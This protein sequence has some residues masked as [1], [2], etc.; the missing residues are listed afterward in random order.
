MRRLFHL[1]PLLALAL[2][3]CSSALAPRGGVHAGQGRPP[4]GAAPSACAEGLPLTVRFYDVGQGLAALVRLP[5]GR[6]LLVDTGELAHRSG[7]GDVCPVWHERLMGELRR[8]LPSGRLDLLWI[9]HPHSDHLGG[10]V[11][12]LTAFRTSAYVDNGR[13]AHKPLVAHARAAAEK[14]G[15]RVRVVDPEHRDVPLA[16]SAAVKFS[17]VVPRRWPA[18]CH[19]NENNCSI[20]LRIDYCRSSLLFTGDAEREEEALFDVDRPVTLLQ[21]G[22][23]GSNTSTTPELLA[24]LRPRYAVI[25]VG[26]SDEGT[27]KGFCHPRAITV[28]R[29]SEVTGGARAAGVHAFDGAVHCDG[30]ERA[31]EHWRDVPASD[32]L[33]VTAR[34]GDVVL[35][36]G[37]DGVFYRISREKT[38]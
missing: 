5:D 26:K 38:N 6:T 13:D 8:D 15:A 34:D 32:R 12:V 4:P 14:S 10:A 16:G 30:N 35:R 17:A 36:T 18:G 11:D 29:L 31:H 24:R 23:H 19:T 25:S 27:N 28:R 1:T 7:C 20:G 37:G 2:V 9:T 21:A 3:A 22:H 33:W